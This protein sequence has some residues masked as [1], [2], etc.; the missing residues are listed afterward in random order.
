M[1][2]PTTER[3][4]HYNNLVTGEQQAGPLDWNVGFDVTVSIVVTSETTPTRR[5]PMSPVEAALVAEA[6]TRSD[7]VWLR[8]AGEERHHA[9]WHVWHDDAVCVV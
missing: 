8:V 4:T 5:R 3:T 9:A 1:A 2:Q 6:C 7:L